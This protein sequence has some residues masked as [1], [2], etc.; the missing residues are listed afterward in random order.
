MEEIM[1]LTEQ[2]IH[3]LEEG[4]L[5]EEL[6]EEL[7]DEIDLQEQIIETELNALLV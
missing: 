2:A 4:L 7:I 1:N 6:T 5:T 3:F